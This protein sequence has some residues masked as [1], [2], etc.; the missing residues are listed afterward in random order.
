MKLQDEIYT[1]R[2]NLIQAEYDKLYAN[3][4]EL[5]QDTAERDY[6]EFKAPDTDGDDSISKSEVLCETI[7]QKFV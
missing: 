2:E 3:Y 5:L 1:Q 6:E 4:Q 7:Y